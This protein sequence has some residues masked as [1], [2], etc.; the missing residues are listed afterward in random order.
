MT[1]LDKYTG[2]KNIDGVYQKIINQIPAHEFY[3][4]LFA[5]SATIFAKLH[6]EGRGLLNDI[7]PKVVKLLKEKFP[8]ATVIEENIFELVQY[9]FLVLQ[10]RESFVF[11]DPPYMHETRT[12]LNLYDNELS[13]LD[14]VKLLTSVLAM[15]CNIMI[16]HPKCELY[17]TMLY[18][19]RKIEIKIR[20]NKK[21]SIEI[22]YMN[23]PEPEQLQTYKYLGDNCW[24]RQ[25]IKRKGDQLVKKLS[26]LPVLE[27]KYVLERL[28]E[29]T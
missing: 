8:N 16:I 9:K 13:D 3:Y 28:K 22:L 26:E 29:I 25:R 20:Y 24:D 5:G 10:I 15:D 19:W 7:N 1:S 6:H 4:E 14:H 2:H 17:D 11:L 21:T 18:D 23:Y 12:D 27:R